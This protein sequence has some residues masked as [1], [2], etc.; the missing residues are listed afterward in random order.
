MAFTGKVVYKYKKYILYIKHIYISRANLDLL[1]IRQQLDA[2]SYC[3]NY[4]KLYSDSKHLEK[5]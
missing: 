4:A 5:D 1:C 2:A 3:E